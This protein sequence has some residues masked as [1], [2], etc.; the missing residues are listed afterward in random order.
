MTYFQGGAAVENGY[1]WNMTEWAIVPVAQDGDQ[2]PGRTSERYRRVPLVLALAL[3]PMMGGLFL[4]F[5]PVLGFVLTG[6]AMAKGI[7]ARL[8]RSA[9]VAPPQA[10]TPP[11]TP[12]QGQSQAQAPEAPAP[13]P[14]VAAPPSAPPATG[15]D[16]TGQK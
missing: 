1:Y 16:P 5:L 2:L 13:S 11:Q 8:R 15:G 9:P 10:Q 6:Q 14:P 3:V 12:V 7:A 4:M